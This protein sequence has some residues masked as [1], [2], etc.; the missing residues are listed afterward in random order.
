MED[1]KKKLSTEEANNDIEDKKEV[2]SLDALLFNADEDMADQLEDDD[3]DIDTFMAEYRSLISRNLT[4]AAKEIKPDPEDEELDEEEAKKEYEEEYL[5][6]LPKKQ[7]Q[8]LRAILTAQPP[9]KK[10]R[11]DTNA[12]R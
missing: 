3:T 11:P 5:N 2:D 6:P 9:A 12:G 4:E 8:Q 1:N 7:Q 10:S